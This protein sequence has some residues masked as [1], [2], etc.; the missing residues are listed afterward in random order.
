M[1]IMA[2][3]S[4]LLLGVALLESSHLFVVTAFVPSSSLLPAA[5]TTHAARSAPAP[6]TTTHLNAIGLGPDEDEA[7]ALASAAAGVATEVSPQEVVNSEEYRTSRLTRQD[8]IIDEWYASLL[9][10][11]DEPTHLGRI[12]QEARRRILTLPELKRAPILPRE[13][14]SWTPYQSNALPTS[15]ILPAYGLEQYGLPMP[16]KNAETWRHFDVVGMIGTDY[17]GLVDDIGTDLVL[18]DDDDDDG[19][20]VVETYKAKMIERG[21]WIDD[22]SCTARLVYVD[23]RYCPAL[24][25]STPDIRN[26][27]SDDFATDDS[28]SSAS[29]SSSSPLREEIITCLNRLPDGFTDELAAEVPSGDT[30]HLTSLKSLSG[31]DHNVG[32]PISQFAINNQ[33]GTAC[34]AALNSVRAGAVAL[35]DVAPGT[36][37]GIDEPKPTLIINA[38]TS[39]M[40]CTA[41]AAATGVACH[42]RVL[43]IAGEGCSA[44]LVQSYIDLDDDDDGKEFKA[45]LNNGFTQ[46]FVKGSANMTHAYLEETGGIVTSGVEHTDFDGDDA[47]SDDVDPREVEAKR[48][49]LRNTH[50]ETIDVHV[51]GDDGRYKA[52]IMGLGGNGRSR[53]A[54]TASLLRPGSH[55]S[56]NGFIL[57]GGTQRTETKTNIHHIAQG[58][59]SEQTQRNMVGGRATS[60]FRGRIR[61]EQSAQQT[62]SDQLS[63][64]ILLS[65][66]SRVWTVPSLEIIADDVKCTHG[67]TVSDLSEEELFY[68]RSR[69]VDRETARNMLMY[70]FVDEVGQ[71]VP[72][73]VRGDDDLDSSLKRRCIK[74]LQNVVPQGE[75]AARGEFQSV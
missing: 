66:K 71:A 38:Q 27:S 74:R 56:L 2:S 46:V 43:A 65:D 14:E 22:D 36:D 52:A 18:D 75:R 13:D 60:S 51:T 70:A 67:A 63:R 61:V 20:V 73:S 35:M 32:E 57:A 37:G 4:L 47:S 41:G 30:D 5:A 59:T 10:G 62:D 49:A 48:P 21:V 9:G 26:L 55:A 8:E 12:S 34:F 44:S 1:R 68:L 6:T 72:S 3:S 53:V 19:T 54:L 33:Q 17:S 16:R 23:G 15:P 45:K 50:L 28:S 29:A 11:S 39:N 31:P 69:G 42:P 64:T 25:K 58:T 7:A 40:G 24:S